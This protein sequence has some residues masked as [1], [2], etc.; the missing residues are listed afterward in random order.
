MS[1]FIEIT[2]LRHGRSLA[3]DEGKIEG[4]YDSPLTNIGVAQTERRL[5]LW[6]AEGRQFDRIISS[7]LQ[8][9]ASVANIISVGYDIPVTLDDNWREKDNGPLAG[10]TFD[11]ADEQ[12]PKADFVN[13]YQPH[14]VSTG[15]GESIVEMYCRAALALQNIIRRG[16]RKTLVISHGKFINA[17]VSVALGIKPSANVPSVIFGSGDLSYI[18][19]AYQPEQDIWWL[20]ELGHL[21]EESY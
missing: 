6:L 9:A 7:T 15:E 5:A 19:L 18:D 4:R 14:V 1:G 12:F 16:P 3:D 10:L 2:L 8:R 20:K 17:A 21:P 13:P 11:E